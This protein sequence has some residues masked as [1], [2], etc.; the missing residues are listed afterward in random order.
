[1]LVRP[2]LQILGDLGLAIDKL[3]RINA[4]FKYEANGLF[5]E[6]SGELLKE[7]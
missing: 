6:P 1:M 5:E 3:T 7:V 2:S 4:Y